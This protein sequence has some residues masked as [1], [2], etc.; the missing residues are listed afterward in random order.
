MYKRDMDI[1]IKNLVKME[2]SLLLIKYEDFTKKT[3]NEFCKI[4]KF[5]EEPFEEETIIERNPDLDKWKPDPHLFSSITS[6]TKNWRDF[7]PLED[8]E[9][10]E[11]KLS[12][13]MDKL[14]FERY[15]TQH[16]Y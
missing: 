9:Y 15:T 6:Q 5:I 14:K 4:C 13:L 2:G 10:I 3:E 11:N 12:Y 8:A 1:A 16:N 7:A